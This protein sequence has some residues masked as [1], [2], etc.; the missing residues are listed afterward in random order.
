MIYAKISREDN[1]SYIQPLESI[2]DAL[3]AEFDGVEQWAEVG[4]RISITFVEM[5]E[6]DYGKLEEF[7]G[8]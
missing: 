1:G 3:D 5:S 8:W 6:E 7:S 2:M 4:D